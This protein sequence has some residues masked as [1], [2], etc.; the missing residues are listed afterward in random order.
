ML[1]NLVCL[2]FD[3]KNKD[4]IDLYLELYK[5]K[6]I[7]NPIVFSDSCGISVHKDVPIFHCFYLRHLFRSKTILMNHNDYIL[8]NSG[9]HKVGKYV[10]LT[11]RA[12]SGGEDIFIPNSWSYKQKLSRLK[13]INYEI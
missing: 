9:Y 11:D 7:Q 5:N 2:Q 10:V 4:I 6:E 3:L 8:L 12:G 1:N 13:E